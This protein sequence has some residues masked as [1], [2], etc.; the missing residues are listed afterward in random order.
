MAFGSDGEVVDAVSAV[1]GAGA[2][3]DWS[4]AGGGK[5]WKK[6]MSRGGNDFAN[7]TCC[8]V[9]IVGSMCE[10]DEGGHWKFAPMKFMI[11]WS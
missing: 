6:R 9:L 3:V 8:C 7:C 11:T 2:E 5:R 4:S 10:L 1:G